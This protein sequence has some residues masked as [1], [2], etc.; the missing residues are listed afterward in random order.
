MTAQS[1]DNLLEARRVLQVEA[2]ARRT[3][4]ERV[5]HTVG[6][7]CEGH[8]IADLHDLRPERR[9]LFQGRRKIDD[10]QTVVMSDDSSGRAQASGWKSEEI[11]PEA[12]GREAIHKAEQGRNPKHVEPG[13]FPVILTSPGI[14]PFVRSIVERFRSQT[15]VLS[16][17]EIHPQMKLKTIA[18]I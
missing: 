12:I 1:S 9:G 6:E 2:Q 5:Q 15:P 13:E 8:V 18:Q 3:A 16:Q 7:R 14:R 11:N 10:F 4:G 17:N